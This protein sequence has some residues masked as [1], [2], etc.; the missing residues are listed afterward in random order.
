MPTAQ[1]HHRISLTAMTPH[2]ERRRTGRDQLPATTTTA[3]LV[4]LA[5]STTL[6]RRPAPVEKAFTV[7]IL[8][9]GTSWCSTPT[10]RRLVAARQTP[11]KGVGCNQTSKPT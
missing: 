7:T 1:D 3:R 11:P 5:T 6:G 9:P 4:P 2:G 8:A 10:A